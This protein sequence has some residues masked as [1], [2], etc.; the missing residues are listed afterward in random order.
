MA[1]LQLTFNGRQL[2]VSGGSQTSR[3]FDAVSG[4]PGEKGGF[5]Y[6]VERQQ[7]KDKGPI[8]VGE[9]YIQ[10]DEL[11]DN[12]SI[13]R[14]LMDKQW[15]P[16]AWGRYRITI[17]HGTNT[18]THGRSGFFIHGGDVPG[19]AGCIDLHINMNAFVEYMLKEP[20]FKSNAKIKL[21]VRY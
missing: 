19:S 13:L 3:S 4:K 17:H 5:D 21:T 20:D 9:Y 10:P 16:V 12:D 6:S 14:W 15:N 8:P 2:T 18:N 1:G 11:R 7:L